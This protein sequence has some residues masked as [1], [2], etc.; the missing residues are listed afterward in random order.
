MDKITRSGPNLIFEKRVHPIF[1]LVV[2][3]VSFFPLLAPYDL[4]VKIHWENYFNLSFLISLLFSMAAIA[5]SLFNLFIALFAQNQYVCFDGDR[6]TLTH[7][8][9]AAVRAY[10]ETVLRNCLSL[11]W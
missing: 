7:G 8:W 3:L 10:P 9:S 2:F 4:S 5:F 6:S 1:R 11:N